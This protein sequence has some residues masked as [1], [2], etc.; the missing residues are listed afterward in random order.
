MNIIF[1]RVGKKD[2]ITNAAEIISVKLGY[3]N[4]NILV[5]SQQI[6]FIMVG[7]LGTWSFFLTDFL[8]CIHLFKNLLDSRRQEKIPF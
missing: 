3:T 2:P 7:V 1:D 5:W 4:I 6:S 8:N